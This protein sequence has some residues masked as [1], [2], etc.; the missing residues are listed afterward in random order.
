M[1]NNFCTCL[2]HRVL[3]NLHGYFLSY[4][5]FA[6]VYCTVYC[7][8]YMDIF[9][10]I[11]ILHMF[12]APCTAQFTWIFSVIF[13]FCTCLLHRVLHNLYGYFLSN[14]HFVHVYCTVYCTI[15]M[16]SFCQIYILQVSKVP[17]KIQ[18]NRKRKLKH[19]TIGR[20]HLS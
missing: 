15:Y 14:L 12:I 9:C 2:L 17:V 18:P 19:L 11:Y 16:D 10:Q 20:T 5:H 3:H 8:I 1:Q 6:H 7:T 4:L 13:T